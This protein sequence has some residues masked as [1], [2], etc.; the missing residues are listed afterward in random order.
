MRYARKETA[1]QSSSLVPC[2]AEGPMQVCFVSGV[3][4]AACTRHFC[5][6]KDDLLPPGEDYSSANRTQ[7]V[8]S[9]DLEPE[10]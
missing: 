6:A 8:G 2:L 10:G 5:L 4:P 7:P 1:S 3:F 9:V